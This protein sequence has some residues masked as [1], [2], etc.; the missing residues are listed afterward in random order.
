MERAKPL[1]ATE[2]EVPLEHLYPSMKVGQQVQ[3]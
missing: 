2:A 1:L 3:K